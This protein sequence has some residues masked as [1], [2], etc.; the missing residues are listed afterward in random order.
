[1][2]HFTTLCKN[3]ESREGDGECETTIFKKDENT[4]N[5]IKIYE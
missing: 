4:I 2:P 5:L 3:T 1:M